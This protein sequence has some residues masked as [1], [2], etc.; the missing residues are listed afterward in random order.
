M[1]QTFGEAVKAYRA[2]HGVS[3]DR[4]S[5]LSGVS[6]AY[7][8]MLERGTDYRTGKKISPTISTLRKLA[9]GMG[10]T[11]DE[12]ISMVPDADVSLQEEDELLTS[13]SL[14][15]DVSEEARGIAY[16]F[17]RADDKSK[18]IVRVALTDYISNEPQKPQKPAPTPKPK[19]K[20]RKDGFVEIE[21]FEDQLPAAGYGSYFDTP[22]SHTEQYPAQ[23]VPPGATFGVPVSG[24]SMEPKIA[25]HSTVFI[26]STPRVNPNEIG[27]FSLNGEPYIKKLIVDAAKRE[28]RLHSLNPDYS[29]IVVHEFDDLRTFGRVVGSYSIQ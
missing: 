11:L 17:D 28:V 13:F 7:I 5:E 12:F 29:D 25:N 10:T 2:E 26:Q 20:R 24:N 1:Y 4:L 22:R 23:L 3:M 19:V 16:A 8:S 18:S 15:E 27:L 9:R 14:L 6:K 21:I